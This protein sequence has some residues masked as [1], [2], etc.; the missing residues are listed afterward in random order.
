MTRWTSEPETAARALIAGALDALITGTH[1]LLA[2]G[3]NGLATLLPAS[4]RSVTH[5]NRR[6]DGAACVQPDPPQGPYTSALLRLPKSRDEQVMAAHQCLGVLVPD[7]RLIIYGGNDEGIRTVQKTLVE[8]GAITTLAARGHGRVLELRRQDVIATVKPKV[9]DWRIHTNSDRPWI[10]YPGLFASGT[11]DAGTTLLLAHLPTLAANANV[12]DYGAG[13][14][15]IAAAVRATHPT[16]IVTALDN[17]SVALIAASENV[18]GASLVLG[19]SLAAIGTQR[20]D[21]I[22]SNPPL[23][24]GFKDDTSALQRLITDAPARLTANGILQ[25]VVQRRIAL[26]RSLAAAFSMVEIIADD[27]RYRVWRAGN[28]HT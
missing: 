8:L 7:G 23:H 5:W 21:L 11:A 13:P 28:K 27:G 18:R 14:G 15:A 1:V 26:D 16:S 22:V 20:F 24:V 2:G 4:S 17:D 10:T 9:T 12:L 19:D 25:L 6:L 3:P